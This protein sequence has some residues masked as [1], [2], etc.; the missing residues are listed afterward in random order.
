MVPTALP[1]VISSL[2]WAKWT[3]TALPK[4]ISSLTWAK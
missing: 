2:T 4:V 1:K 3:P